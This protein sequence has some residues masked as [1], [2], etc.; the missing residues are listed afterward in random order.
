MASCCAPGPAEDGKARKPRGR[1]LVRGGADGACGCSFGERCACS[2][3]VCLGCS[4]KPERVLSAALKRTGSPAELSELVSRHWGRLNSVHVSA[5]LHSLAAFV[6]GDVD[7]RDET[8]SLVPP[9]LRALEANVRDMSAR[10]L[11]TSVW[12]LAILRPPADALAPL[13]PVVADALLARL[14]ERAL[15]A[16]DL[17]VV[18]WSYATLGADAF[19]TGPTLPA[20]LA[21]ALRRAAT[22]T[23]SDRRGDADLHR[24]LSPRDASMATWAAAAIGL[25]DLARSVE[26]VRAVADAAYPTLSGSESACASACDD[27]R[28]TTPAETAQLARGFASLDAARSS[29]DA[30]S[31]NDSFSSPPAKRPS[32]SDARDAF[33]RAIAANVASPTYL[34]ERPAPRDVVGVLHAFAEARRDPGDAA[35]ANACAATTASVDAFAPREAADALWALATLRADRGMD[36]RDGRGGFG[37]DL[38]DGD[39]REPRRRYYPAVDASFTALLRRVSALAGASCPRRFDA[40]AAV[41]ALWAAAAMGEVTRGETRPLWR[42]ALAALDAGALAREGRT[43]LRDAA[44]RFAER[45]ERRGGEDEDVPDEDDAAIRASASLALERLGLEGEGEGEGEDDHGVSDGV[46]SSS[47]IFSTSPALGRVSATQRRVADAAADLG[48]VAATEAKVTLVGP[49]SSVAWTARVDVL[50]EIPAGRYANERA[51]AIV[52]EVDG[53]SHFLRGAGEDGGAR[54]RTGGT[55]LRD[56]LATRGCAG[57]KMGRVVL[58]YDALDDALRRNGREGIAET[59]GAALEAAAATVDV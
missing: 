47:D 29:E 31:A 49:N 35:V 3:C 55:A 50:V 9:L 40:R 45:D 51:T 22:P 23:P 41:N 54:R 10:A 33:W 48:L 53:P 4:C 12:T 24:S 21:D 1:R 52:V 17:A 38:G 14:A 58:A 30:S 36:P 34:A 42:V 56:W 26:Y 28:R 37:D 11:C 5:A 2:T 18:A 15:G 57:A 59:L 39:E 16:R 8:T 46:R 7:G 32:L 43:Q 44:I 20:A 6:S 13:A 25:V 27:R 19:P